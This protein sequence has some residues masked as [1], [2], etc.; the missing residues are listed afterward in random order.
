[1][2]HRSVIAF[3]IVAAAMFAAPQL[4]HDLQSFTSALGS[5]LN[6]HL[7]SAFLSLPAAEGT[8]PAAA[9]LAAGT[10]LASCPKERAARQRK[11]AQ[12]APAARAEVRAAESGGD[13]LAMI[14][15]PL[16]VSEPWAARLPGGALVGAAELPREVS[17]KVAM[18]IPPPDGI[19]PA[20][21]RPRASGGVRLSAEQARRLA[22][23]VRVTY[24]AARLEGKTFE[25]KSD[26]ALRK[27]E[28]GLPGAHGFRVERDGAKPKVTK[29]RRVAG[30][31]CPAPAA[32]PGACGPSPAGGEAFAPLP[33]LAAIALTS[34][35]GE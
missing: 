30:A 6:G 22:E 8:T 32:A 13:R 7:M 14:E 1:M 20:P 11:A 9:P 3:V 26:E 25:W 35:V 18:I 31:N 12:P 29:V 27:L 34:F 24:V 10:Q 23:D 5:C 33:P 21:A 4:S 16:P 28:E 17:D 19:D 15:E 2:K